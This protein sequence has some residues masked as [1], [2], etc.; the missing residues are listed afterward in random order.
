MRDAARDWQA[1]HAD[2][3]IQYAPVNVTAKPPEMPSWL[4]EILESIARALGMSA[5]V[6][7]WVFLGCIALIVVY[8]LWRLAEPL[9]ER[10]RMPAAEPE[11]WA[12][13]RGEALALLEDADRLAA[14][15][16]Y[17]EAAHLLLQ[18]SVAQIAAARPDWV[19]PA[20]TAREIA[21]ISGLPERARGAFAAITARVERSRFALTTLDAADWQAARG[22]YTQFA[23]ERLPMIETPA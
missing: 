2:Q 23:L 7:K 14:E 8:A 21:S 12:P 9:F 4:T 15:G 17:D 22:A 18:R 19:H 13:E 5:P 6:L 10:A 20:S 3:S 16:R 11:S 1:V